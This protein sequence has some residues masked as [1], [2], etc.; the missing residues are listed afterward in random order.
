MNQRAKRRT[1]VRSLRL[2]RQAL[3]KR[4]D[5]HAG[6]FAGL[7]SE[8][9]VDHGGVNLLVSKETLNGVQTRPA[10]DQM[11][12]EAVTQSVNRGVG[13]VEFLAGENQEALK[14]AV[15]HGRSGCVH[16]G[17]EFAPILNPPSCVGKNEK[18]VAVE[19]VVGPKILQHVVGDGNH[20]VLES[21]ALSDEEFTFLAL[22]VVNGERKAFGKPQATAI[23]EFD[24][25]A[26][27]AQP[28]VGKQEADLVAGEDNRQGIKIPGADLGKD[29]Q[30]FLPEKILKEG[31]QAGDSLPHGVGLP[32]L[33]EF[34][35][36]Q[37]LADLVFGE[38]LRIAAKMLL[39]DAQLAVV[40]VAGAVAIMTQRQQLGVAG[41][42]VVGMVVR[43]WIG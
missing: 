9:K 17:S 22:D 39:Q 42:G 23:N 33:F 20:S 4:L 27:A 26:V 6:V 38:Q 19:P 28:D 41:H 7:M 34:E 36:K 24:R 37:I 1:G 40:G 15:R 35:K 43:E 21:L 13:N 8:V 25:S 30:R 31:L 2:T 11:S 3:T 18:G 12:G 16:A 5:Q 32:V 14:R 10:F 29:R